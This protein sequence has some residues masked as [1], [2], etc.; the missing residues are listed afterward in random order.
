MHPVKET[1]QNKSSI[2]TSTYLRKKVVTVTMLRDLYFVF[3][4][5]FNDNI[6]T[7]IQYNLDKTV[8][9]IAK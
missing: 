4:Q 8:H 9:R 3:S 1:V 2:Y 5:G 6:W 7:V